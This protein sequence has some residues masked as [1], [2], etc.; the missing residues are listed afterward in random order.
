[1]DKHKKV[2]EYIINLHDM[3]GQGAYSKVYTCKKE[4][5]PK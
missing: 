1:M 2:G 3:K 5:S 4:D